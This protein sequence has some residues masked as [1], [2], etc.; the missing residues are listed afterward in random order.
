MYMHVVQYYLTLEILKILE[1]FLIT[2]YFRNIILIFLILFW[3]YFWNIS[4]S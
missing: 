1:I 2:K 4:C 3:C